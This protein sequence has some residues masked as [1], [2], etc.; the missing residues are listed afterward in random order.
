MHEAERHR[1]I[2]SEV[3]QRSIVSINE[4]KIL[5]GSSE[6]TVRRDIVRLDKSGMLRRIRGGAEPLT[7]PMVGSL[8]GKPYVFNETVNI[9]KKIA[10]GKLAS[11]MCKDGDSI[12]INGGTTTY[13]MVANLLQQSLNVLTN[14]WTI[15]DYLHNNSKHT[16]TLPGGTLYREQNIILSP[17]HDGVSSHFLARLMFIGAQG[18][19]S[20]G[21]LESDPLILQAEQ[22]L[23]SQAEKIIVV[24]DSSKF[25]VR[26]SLILCSLDRIDTLITD[27]GIDDE[28]R[29]MLKDSGVNLKIAEVETG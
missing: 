25:Q 8:L 19:N 10:I 9:D 15:A 16:V 28:S 12:I 20:R 29:Q 17:F 6:A 22:K 2:L 23:M 24:V 1:I 26:N 11:S 4:L 5:L 3:N 14:S 21:L 7:P 18:V 13:Q 27:S